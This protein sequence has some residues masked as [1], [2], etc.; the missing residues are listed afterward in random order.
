MN[1]TTFSA[2]MPKLSNLMPSII[3]PSGVVTSPI[4]KIKNKVFNLDALVSP[5]NPAI[6][7]Y[8]TYKSNLVNAPALPQSIDLRNNLGPIRD[9]GSIGSCV[10]FGTSCMKEWQE[11]NEGTYTG[12][13]SP[14]FIYVNRVN[15]GQPGMYPTNACDI[16]TNKGVCPETVFSYSNLESNPIPDEVDSSSLPPEAI[17]QANKY[18]ISRS[19]MVD[20]AVDLQNAL[21][22]NGPVPFVISIFGDSNGNIFTPAGLIRTRMWTKDSTFNISIGRHCMCFVGYNSNG[23][24]V[25]NSWGLLYNPLNSTGNMMGYDY[26]PFGDFYDCV[27]EAYAT[28]DII[29]PVNNT[30]SLPPSIAPS[31]PPYFPPSIA[32]S[33]APYFAPSESQTAQYGFVKAGEYIQNNDGTF[34][35]VVNTTVDLFNQ[36]PTTITGNFIGILNNNNIQSPNTI[37]QMILMSS[38]NK[39]IFIPNDHLYEST[40]MMMLYIITYTIKM[41]DISIPNI[42]NLVFLLYES[43]N[44]IPNDII[45]ENMPDGE[46]KDIY[47]YYL[48]GLN[49]TNNLLSI[50][51]N[52]KIWSDI[53]NIFNV[54]YTHLTN[55]SFPNYCVNID[56]PS[57]LPNANLIDC[58]NNP[59]GSDIVSIPTPSMPYITPSESDMTPSYSPEDNQTTTPSTSGNLGTIVVIIIV[60][61]L[62]SVIGKS[63]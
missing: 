14:A 45:W 8:S 22:L 39:Y 27:E 59:F 29:Q 18:R 12:Y 41:Y 55:K 40:S 51:L 52:R 11:Y 17:I 36:M 26:M 16:L 25:R 24:I 10:A 62:F 50:N 31:L 23:F 63:G 54:I 2:S 21:M 46:E 9:Q 30:P 19:V 42:L 53:G 48:L 28:T 3:S 4:I 33:I 20:S 34:T 38:D 37:N 15:I 1:K 56:S 35:C 7:K 13:L 61:G 6:V 43:S 32:P 44:Y 58:R 47:K 60:I 49:P 5:K 57:D